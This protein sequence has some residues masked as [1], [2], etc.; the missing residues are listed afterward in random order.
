VACYSRGHLV[1]CGVGIAGR[2]LRV[3]WDDKCVV[4]VGEAFKVSCD[5]FEA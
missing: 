2:D 1:A 3:E 5:L 4:V